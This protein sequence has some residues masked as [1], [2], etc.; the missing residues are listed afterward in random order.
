MSADRLARAC[1]AGQ[2]QSRDREW[3][4]AV[5]SIA[6]LLVL[7]ALGCPW[8]TTSADQG[9]LLATGGAT[10]IEGS[11][12]GG[13]VPWA[14]LAGY[15]TRDGRSGTAFVTRVDTGDYR[16]DSIGAAYSFANRIEI[17][18]AR[19]RFDLGTLQRTLMLPVAAFEM[20][21]IGAKARLGG[22]LVYGHWPQIALGAHYKRQRDFAIPQAVGALDDSDV[23]VYLSATR[24]YLAG[25][26]GRNLLLNATLRSTRANQTGL[27][28]FGGDLD[29]GRDL[30]F[31]GSAAVLLDRHWAL[32]I[33]Y[34]Q[35]PDN[36][37][38]AAEHDWRDVFVGWFPNKRVAVVAAWADLG[39][40]ATLPDQRAW[41][42]S[43]QLSF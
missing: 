29:G 3:G 1:R 20:D 28:G 33:E 9:R 17:S 22:D 35:K 2:T 39:S 42:L 21:V 11:A 31:E 18:Y 7:C 38:F 4:T 10:Q 12:G 25:F 24:L 5:K 43:A 14:V 13:L 15:G 16:L 32:G 23:D 27:L 6:W 37:G 41:Y 26:A 36:L 34:R 40:I 8:K 19:Q 30:V